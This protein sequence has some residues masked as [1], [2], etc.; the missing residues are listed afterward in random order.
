MA[1]Q[2]DVNLDALASYRGTGTQLV[3]LYVPPERPISDVTTYIAEEQRD[4]QNIKSKSTRQNVQSALSSLD[5]HLRYYDQ[6]PEN[7]LALFSGA[8]DTGGGQTEM[9]TIV[10]DDLPAPISSFQYN[11]GNEFFVDPLVD[12]TGATSRYALLVLD[13]REA[14]VGW[15]RGTRIEHVA[16]VSSYVPGKHTAGGQSQQRFERIRLEAIDNFYQKV[17]SLANETF[18]DYRHDIDGL[19]VGGPSPTRG[20]FLDTEYLH[21]ELDAALL[22][23]FGVSDTTSRGLTL[24]VNA[25]EDVI[26]ESERAAEKQLLDRFFEAVSASGEATYGRETVANY[27][28]MGAVETLIVSDAVE[29]AGSLVDLAEQRGT[30]VE[31]VSSDFE[32]GE[33]FATAFGGIGGLLRFDPHEN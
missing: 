23:S 16:S 31:R 27:L 22:G 2:E 8:V 18:Y 25:A 15:L 26:T 3:S 32:R 19:I 6:S 29:D 20:E 1:Q 4:A 24:L 13:R 21:H 12:L 11:C 33:Q 17:A 10:L 28:E 5:S 9:V 30:S 14:H 7:G